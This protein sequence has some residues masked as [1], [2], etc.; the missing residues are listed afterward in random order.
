LLFVRRLDAIQW[1]GGRFNAARC[2]EVAA[3]VAR[4]SLSID[5]TGLGV[6]RSVQRKRAMPVVLKAVALGAFRRKRRSFHRYKTPLP[7]DDGRRTGLQPA[8]DGVEG[9]SFGQHQDEL[10]AKDVDRWQGTRLSMLFSS[11][12]CSRVRETSL[13]VAIPA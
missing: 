5:A 6:Q 12:C 9:S 2:F 3:G 7:A 10:G 11:N 8:F 4:R 13:L 1:Q